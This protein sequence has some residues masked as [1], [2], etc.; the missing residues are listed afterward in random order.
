MNREENTDKR[1]IMGYESIGKLIIKIS[2]PIMISML[3]QAM[4][5]I[6]D[7]IFVSWVSE[8]ALAAV[9][10]AY[11]LQNLIIAFGIGTAV[12]VNSLLARKLGEGKEE[13]ASSAARHGLLLAFVTY[14]VFA[15]FGLFL[16]R[17]F[18]SAFTDSASLLDMADSYAKI[19]LICSFGIFFEITCERIMQATGDS[20]HP[21]ITQTAGA[22]FNIIFDPVFIFVFDMGV[23]GAAIATVM[24]QILAGALALFFAYRNRFINLRMKNFKA[25]KSTVKDIYAVGF[26]TII[27]NSIGT[28]M[29]SALNGILIAYSMTAVSVF[30][31]YFKLQSFVFMPVFGLS[32]GLIPII[33]YNYGARN[34]HRITEAVRKGCIIAFAIMAVGFLIFQL[35]PQLLLKMFNSTAEMDRIGMISFRIISWSFLFA[36]FSI[37]IG[38]SFQATGYGIFTMITSIGRQLV[39]LVPCAYI[40]SALMGLDGVW[41]AFILSDIIGLALTIILY[42]IVYKKKIKPLEE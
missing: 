35:A 39:I 31:I 22:I 3:V 20:V 27:T 24:G 5:N 34:R 42:R 40:L 1:N 37:A 13:E 33:A 36:A 4:Y 21:M 25:R 18:L 6:V 16:S 32:A 2:L 7:S 15:L 26:P 8:E 38:S 19:C 12:G 30:G 41:Y 11:P 10:L 14:I 9:T 23:A 28:L 29:V 17:P